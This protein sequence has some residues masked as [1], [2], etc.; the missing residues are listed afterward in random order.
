MTCTMKKNEGHVD[1]RISIPEVADAEQVLAPDD[2]RGPQE[3]AMGI[4]II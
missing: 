4:T 1:V 3:T 2:V